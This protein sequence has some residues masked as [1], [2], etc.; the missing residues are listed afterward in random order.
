MRKCST[1]AWAIQV[2]TR[3]LGMEKAGVRKEDAQNHPVSKTFSLNWALPA[4]NFGLEI[5]LAISCN[6]FL[7]VDQCFERDRL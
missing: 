1:V 4:L 2:R 3:V 5:F 6:N 7:L